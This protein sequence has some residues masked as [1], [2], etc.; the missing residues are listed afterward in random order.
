MICLDT[1]AVIAAINRRV[2]ALRTRLQQAFADRLVVGIPAIV[3]YEMWYM[4]CLLPRRLA[5]AAHCSSPRIRASSHAFQGCG[6]K[7]GQ[8]D[9]R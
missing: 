7:T 3:L 8:P 5:D 4:T 2:P 9:L 1:N 6:W